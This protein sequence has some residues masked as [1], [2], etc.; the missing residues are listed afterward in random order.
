MQDS[1]IK[2]TSAPSESNEEEYF[3]EYQATLN[4]R[5]APIDF[6]RNQR[7]ELALSRAIRETPRQGDGLQGEFITF[8]PTETLKRH[9]EGSFGPII[10]PGESPVNDTPMNDFHAGYHP[11]FESNEKSSGAMF[12]TP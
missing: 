12:D 7:E 4:F 10:N 8:K 6:S 1:N 2:S 11:A 9:Q 5:M 3:L